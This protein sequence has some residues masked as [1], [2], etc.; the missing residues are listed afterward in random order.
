[1]NVCSV[2]GTVLDTRGTAEKKK[3]LVGRE[4]TQTDNVLAPS[5][6]DGGGKAMGTLSRK[7]FPTRWQSKGV[8][9]G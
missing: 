4:R 6:E 3:I 7:F 8:K 2:P 9:R 5:N 1:M